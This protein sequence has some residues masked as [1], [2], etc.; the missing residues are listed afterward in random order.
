MPEHPAPRTSHR[1]IADLR[2]VV[3]IS[4][5][6]VVGMMILEGARAMVLG[7]R[8]MLDQTEALVHYQTNTATGM[9]VV[10]T[11]DTF[12]MTALIVFLGAFRQLV[13]TNN[14]ELRWITDI[15]FG[16]GIVFVAVTL[17][18]DAMAGGAALDTVGT[19]PDASTIRALTVGHVL[20]FGVVGCVLTALVMAA[21][22]VIVLNSTVLP[23]WVGWAAFGCAATNMLSVPTTF[24]GT[25]PDFWASSGG[26]ATTAFATAP[27][28]LWTG[29]VGIMTIRGQRAHDARQR[30]RRLA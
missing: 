11:I 27:F 15:A 22:G 13:T 10:V 28:L 23:R 25:D 3:G 21:C 30:E 26:W 5:F 24:L 7:R 17:V 6:V 8:P 18:G 4:S 2:R 19:V 12:L 14:R 20:M 16:A 9:L 29:L 1:P